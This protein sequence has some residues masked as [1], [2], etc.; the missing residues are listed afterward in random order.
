MRNPVY[1]QTKLFL[2]SNVFGV[3]TA[4]FQLNAA[5]AFPTITLNL[6]LLSLILANN[7][8]PGSLIRACHSFVAPTVF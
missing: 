6:G 1:S 7:A 8:W 3:Y 5:R 2:V 4:F